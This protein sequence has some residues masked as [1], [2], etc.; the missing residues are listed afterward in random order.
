MS[1]PSQLP[2]PAAVFACALSLWDSC[3]RAAANDAG[4]NLSD[5]YQGIDHLMRVLMSI[6]NRFETWSCENVAFEALVEVWPYVLKD[7][8][9]ETCLRVLLPSSLDHFDDD[10]C[11]R[12]ALLLRLPVRVRD[13]LRV[14]VDI[15][16]D[17]PVSGSPFHAFRILTV[18]DRLEEDDTEPFTSDDEPFDEEWGIPYFALYGVGADGL[19]EHIADRR[20]YAEAAD[21]AQKLAPGLRLPVGPNSLAGR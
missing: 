9:G 1:E 12:I 17:N 7:R 5:S 18:R 20:T 2:D 3:Q 8:F 13:H 16:A 14:P 6:G 10:D 15:V 19:R 21:L 11:L 4:L